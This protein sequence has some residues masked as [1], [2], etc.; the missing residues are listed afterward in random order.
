M[1]SG[2]TDHYSPMIIWLS[3]TTFL[4][5]LAV[6]KIMIYGDMYPSK[7]VKIFAALYGR[8]SCGVLR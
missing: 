8:S 1:H 3:P 4:V 5:L 6:T 2:A 7:N